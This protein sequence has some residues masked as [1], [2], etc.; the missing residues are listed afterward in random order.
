MTR[1]DVESFERFVLPY[2]DDAYSLA[3]LLLRNETDA[4]DV[5]QEAMLRALRFYEGQRDGNERAWLLTIVRNCCFT[6]HRRRQPDRMSVSYTDAESA[7]QLHDH[8]A[9][10]AGAVRASEQAA[11]NRAL[12]MLPE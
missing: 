9:V 4:Q 8:A 2:L 7:P 10:D 11:I 6:W 1:R 3:C 12:H 5:V